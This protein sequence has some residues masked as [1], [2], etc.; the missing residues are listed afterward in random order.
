MW[1]QW[2][3]NGWWR[4]HHGWSGNP[5]VKKFKYLRSIVDEKGDVDED[6]NHCIKVGLQKWK[7]ASGVLCDKKI[8][9]RLKGR[10]YRMVV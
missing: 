10:V 1:V 3:G 8:P 9:F 6:V 2:S 7:K 4:S 5:R